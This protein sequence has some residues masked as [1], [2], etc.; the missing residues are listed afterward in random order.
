[1]LKKSVPVVD[2][3]IHPYATSETPLAPFIPEKFR[4]AVAQG[5]ASQPGHGY[6][7][8]FGVNRRDVE[9]CSPQSWAR[10]YLD[11]YGIAF[12]VIQPPGISVSLAHDID[13]GA[14]LARAWNDWQIEHWLRAD[15]RY[16]GSICINANDPAQAVTEIERCAAHPQMV[17]VIVTGESS[18]LYGH[19]F[20]HPIYAACEA[21]GLPFAMHPGAEGART[22]STP[23]GAAASYFEWHSTLPLTFMAHTA[24]LVCNGVFEKFPRFKVVLVEGGFGWLPHLMWRLDKNFKALRSTTPW[25]KRAPSETIREHVRLTSQPIE[26]PPTTQQFL[27]LLEMMDAQ[28]T[29]LFSSDF[30]HWDFDDPRRIFPPRMDEKLLRRILGENAAQLYGLRLENSTENETAKSE[31]VKSENREALV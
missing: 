7:N 8:P 3:D 4:Q 28:N 1:M 17:Q 27:E 20:Y 14:A 13:V 21:A 10:D 23:I 25:L 30:P 18:L 5:Q 11:L 2:C 15:A 29:L 16:L 22:P 19:R 9:G 26:E 24:S 31:T 12:A 6:Q